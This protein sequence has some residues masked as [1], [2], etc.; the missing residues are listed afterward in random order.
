[1]HIGRI[2]NVECFCYL[3]PMQCGKQA[4]FNVNI[5]MKRHQKKILDCSITYSHTT[6]LAL[7]VIDRQVTVCRA[8]FF[9]KPPFLMCISGYYCYYSMGR[10]QTHSV[11]FKL[12][13]CA[14]FPKYEF[15]NRVQSFIS[16]HRK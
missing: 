5:F 7:V 8:F 11:S 2:F 12:K 1:M 3:L 6:F 4:F 14:M 13:N 16:S 15:K 10:G 9:R